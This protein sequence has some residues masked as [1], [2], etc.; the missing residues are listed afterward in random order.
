MARVL[1]RILGPLLGSVLTAALLVPTAA[2]TPTASTGAAPPR[3]NVVVVMMDDFSLELLSTMREGQRM[4]RVGADF[5]RAYVVDSLCCPS[6]AA[7]QTGLPPHLNGVR[8]NTS[9][10]PLG[11]KGG[12]P[13]FRRHGDIAHTFA[14]SLHRAG[15]RTSLVGKYL[16]EYG[17]G[18]GRPPYVRGW[19]DFEAVLAGGYGG[20][21]FRRTERVGHHLVVHRYRLPSRHAS[22]ATKDRSYAT[23]VIARRAL[24]MVRANERRDRPYL[25]YVAPYGPHSRVSD[26]TWR[27]EP[28]FPAAFRDRPRPGH[29]GGSCGLRHC[30]DLTVRDLPGFGDPTGD[31]LATRLS[32][33]GRARSAP[34]WRRTGV[35]LGRSG[36]Q[37][38]LRDRARMVQS[39]DRM[40][41]RIRAAVGPDTYV[42]LTS[43]NGFHLGQHGLG[44]GKG[45]P[46][47]SDVHVPLLVTGPDVVPGRRDVVT[48]NLDL[49]S[50]IEDLA[51]ARPAGRRAGTSLAPSL[52]DPAAPGPAY[53]FVE[54]THGPV[55][56]GEPD[57]DAGTGGRLDAIPS[58][59][60]VRSARGLLV[61][62]DLDPS[63]RGRSFA[64]ELYDYRKRSW[65]KRNVYARL[66]DEPW[67]RDLRRR[68]ESWVG[69]KPEECRRLAL[70]T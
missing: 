5:T 28:R 50:T 57:A 43:D 16:N 10:G 42:V 60:G 39:I 69:C 23:N 7:T 70:P 53:A 17:E 67:V 51:G 65:E 63:W 41:G 26:S 36:A 22:R 29:P 32:V 56:P 31:N 45:T 49:A 13:A 59:V 21:N 68:L 12:F 19:D 6:R 46:Y 20:W 66:H 9:G 62:F 35:H 54:H 15:Y 61:R 34:S 30:R 2:A 52:R 4:R 3:P 14:V 38:L 37:H 58:Y 48:T 44:G 47:D 64:W 11:P 27:G 33:G 55:R 40:L 1:P 24:R 18:R 8:T 25:L